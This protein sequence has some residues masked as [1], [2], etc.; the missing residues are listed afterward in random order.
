[1]T[2]SPVTSHFKMGDAWKL[3]EWPTV[4]ELEHIRAYSRDCLDGAAGG[5]SCPGSSQWKSFPEGAHTILQPG[6]L[7]RNCANEKVGL[8][9]DYV[10]YRR[11]KLISWSLA[12]VGRTSQKKEKWMWGRNWVVLFQRTGRATGQRLGHKWRERTSDWLF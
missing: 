4:C 9:E 3:G 12:L 10:W 11:R 7:G 1:M 8:S 5:E 6:S 2:F